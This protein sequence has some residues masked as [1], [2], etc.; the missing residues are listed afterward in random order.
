MGVVYKAEDTRLNRFVA[1]KF[2]PEHPAKDLQS[3]ERFRREAKAASALSHPNICTIYYI[4]EEREEPLSPW[5]IGRA[6]PSSTPSLGDPW[7]LGKHSILRSR[8]WMPSMPRTRNEAER[9]RHRFCE[10]PID[11]SHAGK[12][13]DAANHQREEVRSELQIGLVSKSFRARQEQCG[14]LGGEF[15]VSVVS[16]GGG[17][18]MR[19]FLAA[20][21]VTL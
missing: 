16:N 20:S 10:H 3:L 9:R 14:L 2:L 19:A 11:R 18:G 15:S 1:L 13:P 6:R 5:S 4:G 7:S 12:G 8:S 21:N 17:L